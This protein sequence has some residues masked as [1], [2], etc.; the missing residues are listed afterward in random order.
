MGYDGFG[1]V[2]VAEGE[3][4]LQVIVL[5]ISRLT[6]WRLADLFQ[7]KW[8]GGGWSDGWRPCRL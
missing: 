5:L 6:Y 8:D 7:S 4:W 1:G 2:G 3:D